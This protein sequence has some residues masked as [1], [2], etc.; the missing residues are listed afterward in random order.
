[1][2]SNNL[3]IICIAIT[4]IWMLDYV[5]PRL[6]FGLINNLLRLR[7]RLLFKGIKI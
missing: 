7:K 6:F 4:S 5:I 2:T 3:I 1:M